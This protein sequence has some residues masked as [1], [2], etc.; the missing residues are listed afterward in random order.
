MV[1]GDDLSDR[2]SAV[3]ADQGDVTYVE[4]VEKFGNRS[5][6]SSRR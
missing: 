6:K 2:A 3:V 1:H 5:G 4:V